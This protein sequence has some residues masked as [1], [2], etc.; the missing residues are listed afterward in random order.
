MAA[1]SQD[2]K[3]KA[4]FR[5]HIGLWAY[6][7]FCFLLKATDIRLVALAGR[8]VGYLVW[9]FAPKRRAIV[10]RNLRIIVDPHPSERQTQ[11]HGTA[12]HRAYLHESGMLTAH[13][14]HDR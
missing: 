4:T 6:K 8:C 5:Q 12:K 11:L 14:A 1:T 10:A 7:T 13:R 3:P 9:M 2:K